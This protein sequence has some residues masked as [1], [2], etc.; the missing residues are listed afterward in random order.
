M[1]KTKIESVQAPPSVNEAGYRVDSGEAPGDIDALFEE[2]DLFS[3]ALI[4]GG[5][6]DGVT[7]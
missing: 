6:T 4:Q 2:V 7:L 3:T 5:C 1:E